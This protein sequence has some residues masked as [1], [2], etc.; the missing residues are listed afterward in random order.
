MG[1]GRLI[2]QPVLC[3]NKGQKGVFFHDEHGLLD[4][5]CTGVLAAGTISF[6]IPPTP[7]SRPGSCPPVLSPDSGSP[8]VLRACQP[9]PPGPW[10]SMHS[11]PTAVFDT[12]PCALSVNMHLFPHEDFFSSSGAVSHPFCSLLLSSLMLSMFIFHIFVCLVIVS[13][14]HKYMSFMS[15]ALMF[16]LNNRHRGD[17]W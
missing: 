15:L 6:E 8:S 10:S 4:L 11:H 7:S 5:Q 2:H 9:R 14:P 3:S 17:T 12:L 16:K 1:R 13:F